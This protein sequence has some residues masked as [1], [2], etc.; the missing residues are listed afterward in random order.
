MTTTN[1]YPQSS[2]IVSKWISILYR[3]FQIYFNQQMKADGISSAEYVFLLALYHENGLS[4]DALSTRQFVDKAATARAIKSLEEK[5]YVVRNKDAHDKR[6]NRVCLTPE[7]LALKDR[8]F[9][10]LDAWNALVTEQLTTE[11]SNHLALNLENISMRV[12]KVN[13]NNKENKHE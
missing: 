11:E 2:P 13:S 6:I 9:T 1:N 5:H 7:G 4:Q 10:V 8:I 3:Q 12:I